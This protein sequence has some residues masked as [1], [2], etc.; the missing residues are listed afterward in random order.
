MK[1][2]LTWHHY[3]DDPWI[4]VYLELSPLYFS[5]D[6]LIHTVFVNKYWYLSKQ[7][8]SISNNEATIDA[9]KLKRYVYTIT[10]VQVTMCV[11]TLITSPI[12]NTENIWSFAN[13]I[14]YITSWA[15]PIIVCIV[16]GDALMRINRCEQKR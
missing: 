15:P 11:L 1:L 7:L 6:V 4:K 3:K 9:K 10:L 2:Y 14:S 8:E 5:F 12:S 16:L 13:D